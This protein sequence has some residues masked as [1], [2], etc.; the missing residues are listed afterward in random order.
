MYFIRVNGATKH[1]DSK[2]ANCFVPNEPPSFPST[3]FNYLAKCLADNFVRIGWPD[4]GDLNTKNKQNALAKCYDWQSVKQYV[5][6]Y[7]D[8]FFNI[9]IGST[10]LMPDKQSPGDL[11]IGTTTSN[12]YFYYNVPN[13]PYEC[14][15]RID[16]N[17]D[18][19]GQGNHVIY[20][21]SQLGINIHGGWWRY[22]FHIVDNMDIQSIIKKKREEAKEKKMKYEGLEK[23]NFKSVNI[24][25]LEISYENFLNIM[26]L[27]IDQ[28][29]SVEYDEDSKPEWAISFLVRIGLLI[30]APQKYGNHGGDVVGVFDVLGTYK[31]K[32]CK[33][34]IYRAL[35]RL[36][37]RQLNIDE[38]IL[39]EVVLAHEF[40]HASTHLGVDK[41][42]GIWV[43]FTDAP[44][45]RKEYFAQIYSYILFRLSGRTSHQEIMDRL[46]I[47]QPEIYGTYLRNQ[48]AEKEVVNETLLSERKKTKK[49]YE[50]PIPLCEFCNTRIATTTVGRHDTWLMKQWSIPACAYC[51][52]RNQQTWLT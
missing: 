2:K 11:Y 4:V 17:W 36:C 51:A 20:Q 40:A 7:L 39:E 19:D 43:R 12:Y 45:S 21:A 14:S 25:T 34:T 8:G 44:P 13:E 27:S 26:N 15:H 49:S 16:V 9:P 38:K 24:S 30:D 41:G 46:T 48:D 42:G 22:A 33:V 3:Y 47:L 32:K 31:P 50:K 1:N 52:K 10:V 5:R 18:I 29:P 23:A 37:A 35:I 28:I 6:D